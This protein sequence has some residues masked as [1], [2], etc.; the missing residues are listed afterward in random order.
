[1][2]SP[3]RNAIT[4]IQLGVEDY[5]SDDPRRAISAVRCSPIPDYIAIGAL[6]VL[7]LGAAANWDDRARVSLR[8]ADE[9]VE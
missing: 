4:S 8:A 6:T 7:I 1:M 3:L 9:R 5:T 2:H